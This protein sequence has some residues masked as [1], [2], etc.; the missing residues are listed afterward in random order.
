MSRKKHPR[1]LI[2]GTVPYN[3]QSTSRAFDAYFHN[4]ER[5]N[6][7]QIFSN[8]KT[9]PKGHCGTLYQITDKRL[10]EH[11]FNH[12][13]EVGKIFNYDDLPDSWSDT[14]LEV[15]NGL[16]DTLYKWGSKNREIFHIVRKIIWKKSLW[17]EQQLNE[18]LD[19]F[20][21]QCVFLSFSDDCYIL[22]IALYVAKK[23]N[24]PICS[25]TGDDYYFNRHFSL[26]PFYHIYWNMHM[27]LTREIFAWKGSA[28]YIS[29][30]IR[31]K[32]N[33]EFGIDGKTVYLVS[34]IKRREFRPINPQHLSI[35]YFGNIRCGRN[36]SLNDIGIAL[37]RIN[38]N[39]KLLVYSNENM[40]SVYGVFNGNPNVEFCG[41]I[42]YHE[43]MKKMVASDIV[44]I[45][46]GF[47]KNEIAATRYSLSTKVA[48]SLAS[49][50]NIL[51]YGSPECGAMEYMD[52]IGCATVC[53]NI[54]ELEQGISRLITDVDLQ[55]Q[56]YELAQKSYLKNHTLAQSTKTVETL[57]ENLVKKN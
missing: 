47:K 48:D 9:P 39:Y 51:V 14:D 13:V 41:A 42:P 56:N 24:I 18:W 5:E 43:V 54:E 29:D 26:N 16:F 19:R 15:G 49:G 11:R 46:E 50:A 30:K 45:V 21:P 53:H 6:M 35:T 2:V 57:I 17:N 33:R 3:K 1:V 34:D 12:N 10:L 36:T 25:S 44:T 8:T 28:I 22:E 37:G 52:A 31:D 38:S 27:R 4:W 7:A 40:P 23:Y 32:Y 20:N 55:H